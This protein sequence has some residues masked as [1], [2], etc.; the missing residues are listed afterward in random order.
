MKKYSSI[1]E[2]QI[3]LRDISFLVLGDS[4]E[5]ENRVF[6]LVAHDPK[7]S[8]ELIFTNDKGDFIQVSRGRGWL[9]LEYFNRLGHD[10]FPPVTF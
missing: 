3:D 2:I 5:F 1:E 9:K 4:F 7:K 8:H 10:Y 6:E